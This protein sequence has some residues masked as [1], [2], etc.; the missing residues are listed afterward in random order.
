MQNIEK[1]K[2]FI[3]SYVSDYYSELAEGV[4]PTYSD[5]NETIEELASDVGVSTSDVEKAIKQGVIHYIDCV[6]VVNPETPDNSLTCTG[7]FTADPDNIYYYDVKEWGTEDALYT[8]DRDNVWDKDSIILHVGKRSC[9]RGNCDYDYSDIV[10]IDDIDKIDY[11]Y[12][13]NEII[14]YH[15]YAHAMSDEDK[16][17]LHD[18]LIET[19]KEQVQN[20]L[21]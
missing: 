2:N 9:F 20:L 11:D 14:Y 1:I 4:Y 6:D 19:L 18:R 17:Y 15:P 21:D 13:V 16:E 8:L 7:V 5:Y 3:N 12:W 10:A